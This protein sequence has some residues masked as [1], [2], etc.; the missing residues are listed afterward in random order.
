MHYL[1]IALPKGRLLEPILKIFAEAGVTAEGVSEDSRCLIFT[2]EE[3]GI[4]FVLAK[5]ADIPTYVEYGAADLGVVG[6][7]VLLEAGKDL[8]ELLDLGVG[9]CRIVAAVPAGSG[10]TDVTQLEAGSRIATKF[11]RIARSYFNQRG[12]RVEIVKLNGSIELAPGVGLAE[13]IVD[14]VDTG[15]TLRENGLV[16][17]NNIAYV[18]TRLVVNRSSYKAEHERIAGIVSRLR[19][20]S[21]VSQAARQ[22]AATPVA[23]N[24]ASVAQVA[25]MGPKPV[26]QAAPA[27]PAASAARK[28][29]EANA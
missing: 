28:A 20:V 16:A 3:L 13:A 7:D 9:G 24:P 14:L 11:P 26:S 19:A 23:A 29:V 1:T 21:P 8:P 6:K 25:Q 22:P 17:V 2:R 12:L 18:T 4:R 15:R 27:A 10:V 5:P